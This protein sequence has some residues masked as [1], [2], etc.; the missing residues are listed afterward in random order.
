MG[1]ADWPICRR[2]AILVVIHGQGTVQRL[3]FWV[4]NIA[5]DEQNLLMNLQLHQPE[6]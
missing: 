5:V 3:L 4:A 1:I 2:E 6:S